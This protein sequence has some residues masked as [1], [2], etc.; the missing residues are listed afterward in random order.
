MSLSPPSLSFVAKFSHRCSHDTTFQTLHS[1]SLC[2]NTLKMVQTF[3]C[4]WSLAVPDRWLCL[5]LW[6]CLALSHWLCSRLESEMHLS[7]EIQADIAD[8]TKQEYYVNGNY[9]KF[10][11]KF[12]KDVKTIRKVSL[13]HRSCHYTA[14][15]QLAGQFAQFNCNRSIES[16]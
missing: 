1:L 13:A 6:L 16:D 15:E 7:D 4:A 10:K 3:G 11:S 2:L 9:G 14:C 12:I 5:R 8:A